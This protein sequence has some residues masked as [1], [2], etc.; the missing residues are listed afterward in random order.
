MN[1]FITLGPGVQCHSEVSNPNT[2]QQHDMQ[3]KLLA[4]CF[5]TNF[6]SSIFSLTAN[7][8]S[9]KN[10]CKSYIFGGNVIV[11]FKIFQILW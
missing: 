8:V 9:K 11:K 1:F 4:P 6:K 10:N 3:R 2:F 7:Q 5:V